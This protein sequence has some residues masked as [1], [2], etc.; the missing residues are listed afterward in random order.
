MYQKKGLAVVKVCIDVELHCKC[1][2]ISKV[3]QTF[4]T[5]HS[6]YNSVGV[7]AE[8]KCPHCGLIGKGPNMTRYHFDNCKKKDL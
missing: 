8:V 6:Y 3:N 4:D 2:K 7:F 1:G 5:V